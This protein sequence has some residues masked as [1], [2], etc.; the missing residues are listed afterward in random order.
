MRQLRTGLTARLTGAKEGC[1]EKL[2]APEAMLADQGGSPLD[3][4]QPGLQ[5]PAEDS[6]GPGRLDA[7]GRLISPWALLPR[8]GPLLSSLTPQPPHCAQ[9]DPG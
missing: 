7:E 8:P 3:A 6:R 1:P 4:G 5:T 9:Y 2:T